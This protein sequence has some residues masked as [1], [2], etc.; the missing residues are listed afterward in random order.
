MES[1]QLVVEENFALIFFPGVTHVRKVNEALALRGSKCVGA[2][3]E[4]IG[5][6][7]IEE[8]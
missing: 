3:D 7:G 6:T 8:S 1:S 4:V 5:S 2:L